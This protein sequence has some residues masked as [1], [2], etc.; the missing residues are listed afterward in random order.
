ME[1]HLPCLTDLEKQLPRLKLVNAI[2]FLCFLRKCS[3]MDFFWLCFT[4]EKLRV[5]CKIING[6]YV[7]LPRKHVHWTQVLGRKGVQM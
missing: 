1:L 7:M 2:S 6:T 5:P 4:L 3:F